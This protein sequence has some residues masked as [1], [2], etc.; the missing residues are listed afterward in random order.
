[1]NCPFCNSSNTRVVDKRDNNETKVT[2]RRRECED[3]N[4]R[5]TTYER[6]ETINLYVIKRSGKIEEFDREKLKRGILKTI[7]KRNLDEQK[8]EETVQNIE[9]QLLN[10]ESNEI[11][12]SEIGELVLES[13]REIDEL[14]YLLFA[15]VFKDFQNIDDFEKAL[16][17]L[18]KDRD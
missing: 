1:M 3:C 13:L 16:K 12:T 6:I 2:R 4:K 7:H 17:K 11:N 5:F 18:K 8:I 10:H 14:A 15:S 9:Q